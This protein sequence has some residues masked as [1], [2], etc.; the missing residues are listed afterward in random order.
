VSRYHA[1]ATRYD[2]GFGTVDYTCDG[3][4][5]KA[6]SKTP[7]PGWTGSGGAHRCPTCAAGPAGSAE[8]HG[9]SV[10][11]GAVHVM[12]QLS[13]DD[14]AYAADPARGEYRGFAALHDRMDANMLLPFADDP[15]V[16]ADDDTWADEYAK[17]TSFANAV[18]DEV[19]RRITQGG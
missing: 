19:S 16:L 6:K 2:S 4:G 7:P 5:T 17:W 13:K 10:S 14:I 12:S 11:Q 1:I 3:C 18:M 8:F 9:M 15:D